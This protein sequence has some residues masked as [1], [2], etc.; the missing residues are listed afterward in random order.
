MEIIEL[1]IYL[2]VAILT[3]T[4]II[5]FLVSTDFIRGYKTVKDNMIDED[6]TEFDKVD[7]SGLAS[8][9]HT[10]FKECTSRGE[11]MTMRLYL[12]GEGTFGKADLFDVYKGL[13]W[14]ETIQSAEQGCGAREDIVM[15]NIE[16]PKVL[17]IE[18]TDN[19]LYIS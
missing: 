5:G 15:G 6:N 1:L 11:N 19:V 12:E 14:C 10:M 2:G 18:C 16:I 7:T 8:K 13:G 3:G 17:R 4:L 9:L